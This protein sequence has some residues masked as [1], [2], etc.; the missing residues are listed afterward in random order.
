MKL[1]LLALSAVLLTLSYAAPRSWAQDKGGAATPTKSDS[2][3]KSTAPTPVKR[4]RPGE[5]QT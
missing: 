5:G 3:A 1:R 4:C 2:A